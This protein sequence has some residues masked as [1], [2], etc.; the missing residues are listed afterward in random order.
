MWGLGG[1]GFE[2][3]KDISFKHCFTNYHKTNSRVCSNGHI[4]YNSC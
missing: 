3:V 1:T 4:K 2:L